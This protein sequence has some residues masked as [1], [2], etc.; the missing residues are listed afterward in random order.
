MLRTQLYT[1]AN[2]PIRALTADGLPSRAYFLHAPF[3]L[4]EEESVLASLSRQPASAPF[5]YVVT[6]NVDHVVRL[7]NEP[8][9]A[10]AYNSAWLS[11]C[12][13]RPIVLLARLLGLRLPHL[14]GSNLTAILFHR[15]LAPGDRVALIAANE[16]LVQD[17]LAAFPA[18]EF[19]AFVPPPGTLNNEAAMR[20]CIDFVAACQARFIFIAIGSPT[21]ERI[22]FA[23]FK[24]GRATGTAF[25][26]GAAFE[27]LVGHKR[28][29]PRWV[30]AIG[31]EWM[32]RLL[33]EPRRLWR[34]YLFG[35]L[36]LGTIFANE[37][38][39]R[40]SQSLPQTRIRWD[41]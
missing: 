30:Q 40:L 4:I 27:F 2:T 36:P 20:D 41:H 5:R 17:M 28:R 32:Y 3:D 12:D 21:S 23:A 39:R 38:W 15:T 16:K 25:C 29:A 11:L 6:P 18:L 14:P 24:E 26:V 22:A 34:R 35:V 13:S 1:P 8:A 31:F 10:I 33:S 37:A 19:V 9:L 7:R